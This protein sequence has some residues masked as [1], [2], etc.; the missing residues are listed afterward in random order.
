VPTRFWLVLLAPTRRS[1][2][3]RPAAREHTGVAVK[4]GIHPLA[5]L[6]VT[7]AGGSRSGPPA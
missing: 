4:L 1:R 2:F 5:V 6:I 7:I 3:C